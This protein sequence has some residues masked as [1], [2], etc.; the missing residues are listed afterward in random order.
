[1]K[2]SAFKVDSKAINEGKWV[3]PGEE[4]G[5][6]EILIR[7]YTNAYSDARN[8][9]MRKASLPY[10]GDISRIPTA[11][12]TE[13]TADCLADHLVID[14]RNIVD[15]AGNPVSV[16]TFRECIRSPDYPELLMA[17]IRA[18]AIVSQMRAEDT[19]DAVKN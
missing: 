8:A 17:A 12:S 7:G 3:R 16:E 19:A 14:V 13:I 1:M 18:A 2:L 15:D 6:L 11:I 9:R 10:G 4:T 5:D